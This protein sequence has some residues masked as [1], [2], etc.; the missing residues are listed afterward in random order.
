MTPAELH[1]LSQ[2]LEE[3]P[4]LLQK[5]TSPLSGGTLRWKK[6][7]ADFSILEN[8]CHLRDIE[9]EG[10]AVR[11]QR[12][13]REANPLL[14]DIDGGQLALDRQYNEQPLQPALAAFTAAR[15]SN[16]RVI[17]GL[18]NRQLGQGGTLETVGEITLETLLRMIREHDQDHLRLMA[19]ARDLASRPSQLGDRTSR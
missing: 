19:E 11:I 6:S 10:Y 2:K 9:Q 4:A 16:V 3:T 13:L 5:L 12:L 14:P 7:T 1:Q 17:R 15:L 18:S 8:I